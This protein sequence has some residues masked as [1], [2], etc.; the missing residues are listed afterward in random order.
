MPAVDD[1]QD[2][3]HFMRDL[4]ETWGLDAKFVTEAQ[5]ALDLIAQRPQSTTQARQ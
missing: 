2:A 5:T 1:A 3:G 4:L